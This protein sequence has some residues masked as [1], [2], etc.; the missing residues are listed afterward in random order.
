MDLDFYLRGVCLLLTIP[1]FSISGHPHCLAI[2]LV[3]QTDMEVVIAVIDMMLLFTT[4]GMF[5]LA[6]KL[7]VNHWYLL[8]ASRS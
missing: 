3:T 2:I 4:R 8:L 5:F 7:R 6:Q 1:R